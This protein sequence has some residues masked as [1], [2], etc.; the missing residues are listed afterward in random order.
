MD[1]HTHINTVRRTFAVWIDQTRL[2]SFG[3]I[4]VGGV[5]VFGLAY[6]LLT[7]FSQGLVSN[8]G[9]HAHITFGNAVYFSVVTV[10]TLGYGD[11]V[12]EGISKI[13]VCAEVFFGLTLMGIMLAKLT[14]GRLS[15]HVRRLFRSD[16]Q[17]LLETFSSAFD[18]VQK[19]FADLSPRIGTAFQETP[20]RPAGDQ[21]ITC[22]TEFSRTLGELHI[23]S[24]AFCHDISYEVEQGDFFSDAPTEALQETANSIEQSLFLLGQLILSFPISARPIL[25]SAENRRRISEILEQYRSLNNTVAPHCKNS[26]LGRK[27]E[28]IAERCRT[29]PVNYYSVPE[30]REGRGQPD[31]VLPA[32]DQPEAGQ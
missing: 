4:F 29:I 13:I 24:L 20:E 25:L 8:G 7:P 27:F 19:G 32:V 28:Q 22:A 31:Q 11:I 30:V 21:Q 23:K 16:T 18:F 9:G 2:S 6:Y 15:Y 3:V 10:S 12:P 5:L 17:K 1:I 14:S 26:G